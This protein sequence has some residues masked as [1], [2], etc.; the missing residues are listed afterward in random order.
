MTSRLTLNYG[1][2]WEAELPRR[3]VNNKMNS[4]DPLAINPVSGT[5]GVVTFAGRDGT[6]E[7]AFATDVNNIG[8]RVGFAYQLNAVRPDGA[9]R[10]HRHLLRSDGQQHDWRH[11][12]ARLLDLRQ[13]RRVAGDDAERVP[14][15]R[16]VSGLLAARR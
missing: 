3:E 7:R 4:F 13:L 9:A 6:P 10:R 14:A 11:R 2:R 8:P 16:R 15:A 1:L 5:P 12:G